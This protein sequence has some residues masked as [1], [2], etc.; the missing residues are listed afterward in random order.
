LK[1]TQLIVAVIILILLVSNYLLF[2][3]FRKE[4]EQN[5]ILELKLK[6]LE[7]DIDVLV[8]DL[9]TSRDS[10]RILRKNQAEQN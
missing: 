7:G 10:V 4:R 6:T 3:K 1:L 9:D 5:N 2:D 8:Y